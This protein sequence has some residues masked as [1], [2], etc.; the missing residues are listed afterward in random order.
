CSMRRRR[1]A[2][3]RHT[4]LRHTLLRLAMLRF[5]AG[6]HGL[7]TLLI[8]AGHRIVKSVHLRLHT[9]LI[10][11]GL[12]LR[13]LRLLLLLSGAHHSHEWDEACGIHRLLLRLTLLLLRLL[14]HGLGLDA[15]LRIELAV[16]LLAGRR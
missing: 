11:R 14:R 8:E 6:G 3:L 12:A 16:H 1:H 15:E 9:L 4:L 5:E 13:L 7:Q 10:G 2:L